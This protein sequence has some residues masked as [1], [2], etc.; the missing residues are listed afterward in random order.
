ML[1][2]WPN[3]RA[4]KFAEILAHSTISTHRFWPLRCH[5][6]EGLVQCQFLTLECTGMA[7]LGQSRGNS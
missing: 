6:M 7:L 1:L 3:T 5:Q 2:L 4:P